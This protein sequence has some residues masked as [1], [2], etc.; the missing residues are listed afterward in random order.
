MMPTDRLAEYWARIDRLLDQAEGRLAEGRLPLPREAVPGEA[1]AAVYA[2]LTALLAG[3]PSRPGVLDRPAV[4]LAGPLLNPS[5][6][7]LPSAGESLGDYILV[8]Q[9]GHGGGAM[10]YLAHD[11]RH[12][13]EVAVKVL[14]PEVAQSV[15]RQRFLREIRLAARLQHPHLVPVFDSGE[16]VPTGSEATPGE[17]AWLWFAM[18]WVGGESLADRLKRES[19]L[20]LAEALRI[21]G[22]VAHALE[23]AHRHGVVHRDIKPGNILLADGQALVAD[24]GI[25]RALGG[26]AD[27]WVT[28]TGLIIGTP[29]YMSPEQAAGRVDVDGRSDIYS[30]GCVLYEML[31]GE[32]PFAA[33]APAST[34]ARRLAEP[35]PPI[36]RLRP[37][38]PSPLEALLA[39]ALARDPA[40]RL[41]SAGKMAEA[42]DALRVTLSGR[43]TPPSLP[44]GAARP[45]H[46]RWLLPL[47]LLLGVLVLSAAFILLRGGTP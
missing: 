25:A 15:G 28:E 2:E 39:R 38:L 40:E 3:T 14:L 22:E 8:R 35:A 11:P 20:P 10:V 34:L 45:G 12:D 32:V 43:E 37:D 47:L 42:L 7:A 44:P 33:A 29:A 17:R 1:D 27:D 26:A 21:A 16:T 13:R 24:F 18:P 46:R 19:T 30:L 31:A 41:Q 4:E 6:L 36:H 23:Y 9:A 5:G